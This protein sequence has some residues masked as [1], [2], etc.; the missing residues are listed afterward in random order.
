MFVCCGNHHHPSQASPDKAQVLMETKQA[1]SGRGRRSGIF[2]N[3]KTHHFSDVLGP[4]HSNITC[5]FTGSAWDF[6]ASALWRAM[7]CS[8]TPNSS[9]FLQAWIPKEEEAMTQGVLW[10]SCSSCTSLPLRV[11]PCDPLVRCESQAVPQDKLCSFERPIPP[12]HILTGPMAE[13]VYEE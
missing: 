9:Q 8:N 2:K 6:G 12:C 10:S 5:S 13:A 1:A 3:R 4:S 11:T 7:C